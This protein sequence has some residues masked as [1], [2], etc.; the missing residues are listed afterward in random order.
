MITEQAVL[1]VKVG[2]EAAFEAAFETAKAT[3]ASMPGFR[4]LRLLR[5][6]ER[7]SRYLLLV[8]WATLEDHTV[9]FRGSTEYQEWKRLLHRFYDP[10][11]TVEHFTPVSGSRHDTM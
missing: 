9:G 7:P 10:F 5:C 4:S 8:E 3:I 6:I 1:D 2:Q 11:P